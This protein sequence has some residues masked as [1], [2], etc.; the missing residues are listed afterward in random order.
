VY[1]D[2]VYAQNLR[3]VRGEGDWD[4]LLTTYPTDM[5]L[6]RADGPADNLLRLKPGWRLTYEDPVSA[7]FV[8][9]DSLLRERLRAVGVSE[10]P[11]DGQGLCFP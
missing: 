5:A 8:R 3:F 9:E 11:Y 1:S 2:E 4:A 10:I 7:L 6:V